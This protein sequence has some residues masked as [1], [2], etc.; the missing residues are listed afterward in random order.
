[1]KYNLY[2]TRKLQNII[3]TVSADNWQATSHI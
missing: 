2:K 1:M 3:S